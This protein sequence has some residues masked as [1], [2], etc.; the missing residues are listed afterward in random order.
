MN[1]NWM[2]I[3]VVGAAVVL[4]PKMLVAQTDPAAMP[5]DPQGLNRPGNPNSGGTPPPTTMSDSL[6]APGISGPM[7]LDR[8]FVQT[9]AAG[10]MGEIKL[11][12]LAMQK[13]SPEVKTFAQKMVEDHTQMKKEFADVADS[14]GEMMPK[15]ISK[16]DQAE[17]DKLNALSGDAFDKEYIL[18]TAQAH[19]D[20]LHTFRTE[21]T[22]AS[23]PGLQA[24]VVKA[25]MLIRSH[26][27]L[28]TDL[29]KA[30]GVTLPARP[31]RPAAATP[32]TE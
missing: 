31:A 20:D 6:G 16:E 26:L 28:L 14:L 9:A 23:D 13:G 15:K 19:R 25:S 5:N 27:S 29:A 22:A 21:A 7:M 1:K 10:T 30:K 3:A 2:R 8:Q 24:E 18:F 32:P 4:L 11:G 12:M 17:Y